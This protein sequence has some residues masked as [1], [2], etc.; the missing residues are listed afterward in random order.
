MTTIV[1]RN[2][3]DDLHARLKEQAERNR[4]SVTMEVVTLIERG[5]APKRV[6]PLLSPPIKLKRGPMTDR[7]IEVWTND[8]R[9]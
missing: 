2:L 3:P 1:I 5:T 4:R 7:D 6:A 8:G 9:A